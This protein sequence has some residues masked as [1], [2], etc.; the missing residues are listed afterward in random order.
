[1]AQDESTVADSESE[2]P[3]YHQQQQQQQ[4]QQAGTRNR[5]PTRHG[6]SVES[7]QKKRIGSSLTIPADIASI[8][9]GTRARASFESD[10][11][12]TMAA[13]LGAAVQGEDIEISSITA[14][15]TGE[16]SAVL[17]LYRLAMSFHGLDI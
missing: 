8:A 17:S 16:K 6:D 14:G 1:V 13:S 11:C 4:Q 5:V 2:E 9:P 15:P 7:R 10:F 3:Q 12:A